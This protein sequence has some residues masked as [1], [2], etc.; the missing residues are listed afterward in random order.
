MSQARITVAGETVTVDYTLPA[1]DGP[2][3]HYGLA[4]VWQNSDY[5]DIPAVFAELDWLGV[6]SI[7]GRYQTG[8]GGA[9]VMAECVAR[10]ISWCVSFAP[11]TWFEAGAPSVNS[12]RNQFESR[13][14]ECLSQPGALDVVSFVETANEPNQVRGGG[15]PIADWGQRVIELS[16][17]AKTVRDELAPGLPI[18]SAAMHVNDNDGADWLQVA[19]SY[20]DLINLHSYPKGLDATNLLDGRIATARAAFP[21]LRVVLTEHGWVVSPPCTQTGPVLVTPEDQAYYVGRAPGLLF[22][23]PDVEHAY[24]FEL[25]DGSGTGVQDCRGLIRGTTWRPAGHV[26]RD[27]S[28]T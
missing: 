14:R 1:A 11:E 10:G 26:F 9:Q 5:A 24:L 13:F 28:N 19:G 15:Q 4:L 25:R 22:D 27:L 2:M 8:G 16:Q 23:H 20:A 12:I 3:D 6:R 18:L 17:V 7:R 21:G